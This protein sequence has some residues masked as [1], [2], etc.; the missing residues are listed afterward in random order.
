L[1][2]WK[3]RWYV[4]VLGYPET[5]AKRKAVY[6]IARDIAALIPGSGAPPA[7]I[8]ALPRQGL[9]EASVRTFHRHV[10][11]NDY[12][13]LSHDNVL[14]IGPGQAEAVLAR[15]RQGGDRYALLVVESPVLRSAEK[16]EGA[17]VAGPLG[18][19]NPGRLRDRW[20]GVRRSGKRL[21]IV[22]DAPSAA[23]VAQALAEAQ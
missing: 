20:A 2:F 9:V 19:K 13:F 1:T 6:E 10:L 17:L 7:L 21:F 8:A 14:G 4:S 3:D 5:A 12:A 23:V 22:L 11:Q 16:A 18:G 15:Y